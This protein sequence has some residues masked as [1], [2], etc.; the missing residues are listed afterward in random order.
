[1]YLRVWGSGFAYTG[2]IK[3]VS[4]LEDYEGA[5]RAVK[6]IEGDD[7][8]ITPWVVMMD[9]IKYRVGPN[10]PGGIRMSHADDLPGGRVA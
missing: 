5:G 1:M 7:L 2:L 6:L 9:A 4:G 3:V 8:V 10:F